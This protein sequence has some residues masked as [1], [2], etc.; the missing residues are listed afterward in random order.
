MNK[1]CYR[2]VFNKSRGLMMAVQEIARSH[3]KAGGNASTTA[4]DTGAGTGRVRNMAW[5]VASA[6]G[7]T[8]AIAGVAAAQIVADPNASGRQQATVLNAANGV[9]QVNVQTP[10]AAGVS[11]NVYNRFDVPRSGAILNN[12]R[13]AVQTQLGG[14][15][16]ANPWMA[17][18]TAKVILNEVNSNNPSQLRGYI[19][20]AGAKA[21][22]VI[23]NAAGIAVDG[24]GFIN[25]SRA[26]L[27][28]GAPVL[29]AD[30]ALT[31]YTVQ[32]G[33]ISVDG[34]GLDARQVDYTALIA[35]SVQLNAGLWAQQLEV[36][37]GANQVRLA[38][39]QS[40]AGGTLAPIAGQGAAP[41]YGIDTALLGGMYA[42]KITLVGTE[43]GVG[44]RNA[45]TLGASAGEL[46]VTAEGRL[47]NSGAIAANKALTLKA[48]GGIGNSGSIYGEAAV[49]V[50]AGAAVDNSGTVYATGALE[51]RTPD[52]LS[53]SGTLNGEAGLQLAAASLANSGMISSG[54]RAGIVAQGNIDNRHGVIQAQSLAIDSAGG[55]LDNRS[56]KIVQSGAALLDIAADALVNTHG[57]Q[58]GATPAAA[59][60]DG[61]AGA[62]V[63]GNGGSAGGDGSGGG[64]ATGDDP[65]PAAGGAGGGPGA[66]DGGTGTSGTLPVPIPAGYL[67][68][69]GA[70]NNDGGQIMSGGA[71]GLNVHT[72]DNTGGQLN[73]S[74]LTINGGPFS[75]RAGQISVLQDFTLR[76]GAFDNNSGKLLVGGSFDGQSRDFDNASGILSTGRNLSLASG[77]IANDGGK[78]VSAGSNTISAAGAVGN[79]TGYIQGATSLIL[80]ATGKLDNQA[81]TLEATQ[82]TGAMQ[83]HASAIDNSAGRIA[84]AG[85][86]ASTVRSDTNL[87]NTGAIGANGALAIDAQT[88]QNLAGATV[89]AGGALELGVSRQLDNPGAISSGGG[90]NFAQVGASLNNAGQIAAGGNINIDILHANNSGGQIGTAAGSGGNLALS[91]QEIDNT[92]G[93]MIADRDFKLNARKAGLNNSYGVIH[94]DG[95]GVIAVAQ[96][97]ANTSGVIETTGGGSKL[98]M[99]ADT[100]ENSDGS[101]VNTGAGASLI[102]AISTVHNGGIIA[103]NGQLSLRAASVFNPGTIASGSH[104]TLTVAQL[105]DNTGDIS[106]AGMLRIDG[107]AAEIGNK[108]DIFAAGDISVL[109]L[110]IHNPGRIATTGSSGAR[111]ELQA[112]DLVNDGGSIVASGDVDLRLDGQAANR[113]GLIRAGG[114]LNLAAAGQLDNNA[115]VVESLGPASVMRLQAQAI[116]NTAGRITN[117]GA[118]ATHIGADTSIYNSGVIAGNGALELGADSVTNTLDGSVTSSGDMKLAIAS[119]LRND[120]AIQSGGTLASTKSTQQLTNAGD[121]I[122]Q[123]D[124]LLD[125]GQLSNSDGRIATVTASGAKLT[126]RSH[127]LDNQRGRIQSDGA[128]DL[129]ASGTLDNR[130]G[131]LQSRGTQQLSVGGLL[132]NRGGVVEALGSV[133][134]MQVRA[135][136]IENTGGRI[137]N[138]GSGETSIS[139]GSYIQN[140]GVIGANGNLAVS[141]L[142]VNNTAG[143]TIASGA[144]MRLGVR[145]TLSNHGVISSTGGMSSTLATATLINAAQI[146]A[147]GRMQLA[148][149]VLNN[150]GGQIVTL[151]QSQADVGITAGSISNRSGV[152]QADRNAIFNVTGAVNNAQGLVQA[153]GGVSVAAGGA[154]DNTSGAIEAI[155][156]DSTFHLQAAAI[157]NS[158]GRIVNV[159]TGVMQVGAEG[160]LLNGGLVAGN[161]KLDIG[162]QILRNTA[163]A[164]LS[165]GAGLTLGVS[166]ELT[167]QG[168]INSV[169][170]LDFT[171]ATVAVHNGGGI[172]SGGRATIAAGLFDNNG[173]QL[174]TLKG[175]GGD[176]VIDSQNLSNR[177]GVILADGSAA[178]RAADAADN[179]GGTVQAQ[180]DVRLSAGGALYNNSGVIEAVGTDSTLQLDA[181]AIDNTAGRI[182]NIGSS[183]TRISAQDAVLNSGVIAGNGALDL[184]SASLRNMVGGS[185]TSAQAMTLGVTLQ[186]DNAGAINSAGALTFTQSTAIVNNGGRMVSAGLATIRAG[187]LNNDGG[188]IATLPGSDSAIAITGD[189]MRNRGGSVQ[190]SGD[191]IVQVAGALD[192]AQGLIQAARDLQLDAGGLLSNNAGVIEAVAAASALEVQAGAID[193]GSGR[194]VNV[195]AASTGVTAQAGITSSGTIAGNG[196]LALTAQSLRNNAGG[197]I[198]SGRPM[199]LS[200][201]QRLENHGAIQSGGALDFLQTTAQVSNNGSIASAGQ[202]TIHAGSLNNDG[203]QIATL[204]GSGAD[205]VIESASL[206]NRGGRVLASGDAVLSASGAFDNSL[207]TLQAGQDMQ[208]NAGGALTNVS[209]V[210]ETASAGSAMSVQARSIDSSSGRIV[211]VGGGDTFITSQ[212]SLINSGM[213]AGNG[214]L[215][216]LALTVQNKAGGTLAS[217][218]NLELGVTQQMQN[219]G[220]I[221]SA[222]TLNF[223]QAGASF[224]NSGQ[225]ISGSA[226]VF[227]AASFNNDGGQIATAAGSGADITVESGSIS[228]RSGK[229]LASGEASFTSD[230]GLNNSNGT[231][232]S[233]RDMTVQAGGA[234][235]NSGGA[236][237]AGGASSTLDIR[238]ASVDS[239]GGRIVNV[240][241]GDT[242]VHADS[243]IVN[244]GTLAGNG[245]LELLA[246]TLVNNSGG[247]IGAGGDMELGITGQLDNHAAITSTGK[248]NFNQSAADLTNDGQIVAG[249]TL[250]VVAKSVVNDHGQIAT[251]KGG[252]ADLSVTTNSLSNVQ[253]QILSDGKGT[254]TIAGAVN[255]VQG[256]IQSVGDLV[257]KATGAL[258]NDG[259]AIEAAGAAAN[260]TLEA[261]SIDNGIGRI[262]NIGSGDL[263]VTSQG[264]IGNN[265]IIGGNGNL[266]IK[267][268]TLQSGAGG[269]I[270]SGLNMELQVTQQLDNQG[271]I[272]SG[273][274]LTFNQVAATLNNSG[275]IVAA[276]NALINAKT[277]NNNGGQM[278]TAIGTE[279]DLS[280]ATE[281]LSNDA[282]HI[283]TGRDLAIATRT[284]QGSGE[285][286][287]GR[288]LSLTM[289]GDYTQNNG[290]QQFHSNRDLSL[291]VSGNITNNATFEAVRNLSLSG[292]KVVNNAGA[293]IQGQGV[294]MRAAGDLTN[295]GEINGEGR[296]NLSSGGTVDNSNAIVGGD[297]VLVAQ[298]LNNTGAST[299]LGAT[300]S[301]ALGVAGTVNNTGGATIYSAGSLSISAADGGATG[302]VNNISSTIE[303]SGDLGMNTGTLNNIREN[304]TLAKVETVDETKLMLKPSWY[305]HGDNHNSYETSAANYYPHEVYYVNP[306]DILENET[307]VA[308]DGTTYGRA[309]I[310]THANDS[311]FFWASTGLYNAYGSRLRIN[312][313][314]GTR[315]LYYFVADHQTNPDQGGSTATPD[316]LYLEYVTNWINPAPDYSSSYGS[317]STNCIR[318]ITDPGWVDPTGVFRRDQ[319]RS[320]G[321]GYDMEQSR[322]AHHTAVED[323]I[324]PG[325]GAEAQILSG[326]NMY[327]TVGQA[328]TNQYGNIMATGGLSIDGG[329]AITNEGATL[330]RTH[331]FD[332]TWT[333][334]K[335]VVTPYTAPTL[336]EVIGS[337]A[338]TISGGQGV[339]IS[340]RSFANVDVT[341]GTAGNIRDSVNVVA[342]GNNT[343]TGVSVASGHSASGGATTGRI[344]GSAIGNNSSAAGVASGTGGS[345]TA[346]LDGQAS[347]SGRLNQAAQATLV[348]GG[349]TG[350]DAQ[351]I[352][353]TNGSGLQNS[354][355][356]V[357]DTGGSNRISRASVRGAAGGSGAHSGALGDISTSGGA[358]QTQGASQVGGNANAVKVAPNGLSTINPDSSGSYLFETRSQF[359]N[360]GEWISS[361]YL[362]SALNMDPAAT[363]KRLGDGFYEQRMVRDQLIGLTGRA[364]SD[365]LSDDSRY[366][367]LLN[368]GISFA[369]EYNLRPGIALTADQVAHL[370]SDIVWME[371]ETVSLPDGTVERVLVPKVYLAHAGH[372]A[373]KP[374]G[375]LVTGAGV[376][377]RTADSIVNRGGLID[378]GNGRTVLVA[379]QDILNKGGAISGGEMV[380]KAGGDVIN[381]SLTVKQEYV[382]ASNNGSYTSLSNQASI[383]AGGALTISAGRDVVDTGG[384]ITAASASIGAGRDISFYALQTGSNY[385]SQLA[386]TTEKDSSTT[387]KVGQI[388]TGGDLSLAAGQDLKLSGTQVSAGGNASVL[389][390]RDIAITAV[391]NEVKT[392]QETEPGKS[393]D[394]Q[395]LENQTVVSSSIAAGGNLTVGA[396]LTNTG[397]LAIAGSTLAGGGA[398]QLSATGDV[399]ITQVQETHLSDIDH[400]RES[401]GFLKKSSDTTADFSSTSAV[402]GSSVSGDAVSVKAGN[403]I[404]VTGSQLAADNALT[405]NAGRDLL[406][407]SAAQTNTE[408]HSEEHQK[409]GFSLDFKQGI[410]YSKT[411]SANANNGD[412][413]TQ[414]GS[415]LSGG[416]VSATSGRDT[417]IKGST[418]VADEN[419]TIDA[420][421][422]LS[423]VSAENSFTGDSS[424]SYK[425][426]GSIGSGFQVA[427]GSMKTTNDG[428]QDSVTQVGSQIASLGG[429]VTLKAGEQYTQTSSDVKAPSGDISIVAQD[430]LI[431]SA[432][433]ITNSTDHSTFNKTAIGGTI[434]APV[435]GQIQSLANMANAASNTSDSRMQALAALNAAGTVSS[436]PTSVEAL[437]KTGLQVSISLGNSKSDNK[438]VTTSETAV[439]STVAAGGNVSIVATGAGKDS[440]LTAIGSDI[441]AGGNVVLKADNDVNLLAAQNTASQHSTNSSSGTSIGIGFGIGGT[442]NGFTIDLAASR[443][444]GNADGD[445]ISYTNTHVTAGGNVS[446]TSGGDTTLKGGVIASDSVVAQ[447]GGNLNIESL[448]DSS[449]FDSKQSSSGFNASLCIPPFCYGTSTVGISVG[450]SN[451]NGDFLSVLEQSGIKAGDGGFQVTVV[452]N[453]DLKGG[454][455]SSSQVAVDQGSN[456]L[457]TGSLTSSDLQNKDEYSASGYSLSASVSGKLGDQI[458]PPEKKLTDDQKT[459]ATAASKPGASAGFGS[460]NG[461]QSSTT[462]SGISGGLIVITDPT[463]Q[464]ATGTDAATVL[465]TINRDLTTETADAGALAKGW[466]AQQLQKEIDAQIAI[467]QEFSKQAP[468]AI[469][470][471]AQKQMD[472]LKKANASEAEIAKWDEGG[473]YRVAL[474]TISGAL[475]GGIGGAVGAATVAG[476]AEYLNKLQSMTEAALVEQG[477][478]PEV[479]K[480]FAQGLAETTSLTMGAIVGGVEGG[481]AALAT[482]TNNRQ[483]HPQEAS[484][485]KSKVKDY[486]IL[487]GISPEQAELELTRGALFANDADWQKAYA[488][489]TP[490]EVERLKEAGAYLQNQ[491]KVAGLTFTTAD[492]KQAAFT[493]TKAQ[494]S[495]GNY[496]AVQAITDPQTRNLYAAQAAISFT[497]MGWSGAAT[498]T[499]NTAKGFGSGVPQGVMTSLEGYASLLDKETYSKLVDAVNV[500]V[501]D[502]KATMTKLAASLKGQAQDAAIALYIDWLQRDSAA[503][504]ESSGKMFGGALVD[505]A[506]SAVGAK[507]AGLA[508]DSAE[509]LSR[510]LASKIK[511]ASPDVVAELAGNLAD[512]NKVGFGLEIK[513]Y[514][515]SPDGKV[516]SQAMPDSC[517]P[518]ACRMVI[519]DF[520]IDV[521]EAYLR[522]DLNWISGQGASFR[523]IPGALAIT[524]NGGLTAVFSRDS[525]S[526]TTLRDVVASE[527]PAI[528]NVNGHA[529]VVDGIKDGIVNIRDPLQGAYGISARDFLA[530]WKKNSRV[531][532]KVKK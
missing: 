27:T 32:R 116:D 295:A 123:G 524:E 164:K 349:G 522:A 259:G 201:S 134:G 326:G 233:G 248:L 98:S 287:G 132:D 255:N 15:V 117:V 231:L 253:G 373:V 70:V 341:A 470:D 519:S 5:W 336:T 212:T 127:D 459:A 367:E 297:V 131:V 408:Q 422:D 317:C 57:G 83:I 440:N 396:G 364:P 288:D 300:N 528:V 369:E 290:T 390:G 23:A 356:G 183:A 168:M 53:S 35:R 160:L 278:G 59:A 294:S 391:V 269:N 206:S 434:T 310:R 64:A 154:L 99:V 213:M 420:K 54:G 251:A 189:S 371:S 31:G 238:A 45:G 21:E 61:G 75:N 354:A 421:R 480:M 311:A 262:V 388:T 337:A 26:T 84:N 429:N 526:L 307:L 375:A 496:L 512:I 175:S 330:Y 13:T 443:A 17:Q 498:F 299:L 501:A 91:A 461:S 403:D 442:S 148:A 128:A 111:V 446:V 198:Q 476:S 482:D 55:T 108:G 430:V 328:L 449:K 126:I 94:G 306:D 486:A 352:L 72:L 18:G 250:T 80:S 38:D 228:N 487:K 180:K 267:A 105:L 138:A 271:K 182:V 214:D 516:I 389:A 163:A 68:V 469:A 170:T 280:L 339:S 46:V 490:E 458:P 374:S 48:Q 66:G 357:D 115:G 508:I 362:L 414:V 208:L 296:L 225:L 62:G 150:D 395:V 506:M 279:G 361:D 4:P 445:D 234:L 162:A 316:G 452:G 285:M 447:V 141:A 324:A 186:L 399:S 525:M 380:L 387:Y 221:S 457:M 87:L 205:V 382:N 437:Q 143:A 152:I 200:L 404:V 492:G 491:A 181:G 153:G 386:G 3:G 49:S 292:N 52:A 146:V 37:A 368:S 19:E 106:S 176:I 407:S 237:E 412:T 43:A 202:A 485:I 518:A 439:G 460:E 433:N 167:N 265:G 263:S 298:N 313:S 86:G 47:E 178:I 360:H 39:E 318:F 193:N 350:N 484:F 60:G 10:S 34:A 332:G 140:G 241:S 345:N 122:S 133:S 6:F 145:G 216:L 236:I 229:I 139:S 472:E 347:G 81:G 275:S 343:A 199:A 468:K 258:A 261:L 348:S 370:T 219:A 305:N 246:Q 467:T 481:A 36:Q 104:M 65:G 274:T 218:G 411:E 464:L 334:D 377:I 453:T 319:S 249:G 329:A 14:W 79:H 493:S 76:T 462:V 432:M 450:K 51:M 260:L 204:G 33:A 413:V 1:L 11:R 103:G 20:V 355:S 359:A 273:G 210:I 314:E 428:T 41:R 423:I 338:G 372:D 333:S 455:L 144:D 129:A 100:I 281:A 424:S 323:Q 384:T 392:S 406:V 30:G 309:V 505:F 409:S 28:T 25:V 438:V 466:D 185:V 308:P 379:G 7:L 114:D 121:I 358:S 425:K 8:F 56:G 268:T 346:A 177:G 130:A 50:Q 282:G 479:A 463:K 264:T 304:V 242:T 376:D 397:N 12:S 173:G 102:R 159:G 363:Q 174:A 217:G 456:L 474:H 158:A 112:V 312:V 166:D 270:A 85:S 400:H 194:I 293:V 137:V 118:G 78:I 136:A 227:R 515:Y 82:A 155:G 495:N 119:Q 93:Q 507:A 398:V 24:G 291:T 124:M 504:G 477:L 96:T 366:K 503:L 74:S 223:T 353:D 71:I 302:V 426:S 416:S 419:I 73:L 107:A 383:N 527:G 286:Q 9:L 520:G 254:L 149:G 502:P 530:A 410:G 89:Q 272:N 283:T 239:S 211:N 58:V 243:N 101:I 401:S 220:T 488:T 417:V 448:Q 340:G 226:A 381:Q 147:G 224:S 113:N 235:N 77:A 151:K 517:V 435:V 169:G 431:N 378:G 320:T 252:A 436:M 394:K 303:A 499:A 222:G 301:I 245:K 441:S 156:A 529:V 196:A 256:T 197:L 244:S 500:M 509:Q 247:A 365:G 203:G 230:A 331:T 165:S 67:H 465:S 191:A 22:V 110:N 521:P 195:G 335:G 171:L 315:V 494:F 184:T 266:L 109:A 63:G 321:G 427:I 327:L 179:S 325:S 344:N 385:A 514:D 188:I 161:G 454:V 232:Q 402:V 42:N 209:G 475:T 471:F 511:G 16:D 444:R 276:G 192:N 415:V 405:L 240:G 489:Y 2:V 29:N 40:G 125:A 190:A 277:V 120:G 215:Y 44:V 351:A 451:V 497:D 483:L 342:T 531:V 478:S 418:V 393:Y 90:L 88:M 532:V 284:L 289:E 97:L 257:L 473:E 69:A 207:G 95:D 142:T 513:R 510:A 135:G 322:L 92:S 187:A 157:G 523:D 172:V